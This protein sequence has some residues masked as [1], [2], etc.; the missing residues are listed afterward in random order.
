[1]EPPAMVTFLTWTGNLTLDHTPDA[2]WVLVPGR[3]RFIIVPIRDLSISLGHYAAEIIKGGI[4]ARKKVDPYLGNLYGAL[5]FDLFFE[6]SNAAKP[7]NL[8]AIAL[9]CGGLFYEHL[10]HAKPVKDHRASVEV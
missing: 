8:Y 1:M 3:I 9:C 10:S 2:R 6:L 4:R 7:L 5:C